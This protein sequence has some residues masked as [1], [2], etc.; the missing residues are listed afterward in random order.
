MEFKENFIQKSSWASWPNEHWAFSYCILFFENW[1]LHYIR[2]R[3]IF[4]R[5]LYFMLII[6]EFLADLDNWST[7]AWLGSN[8]V[9]GT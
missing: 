9:I 4:V 1:L 2:K 3:T 5:Y 6:V 8:T 7:K